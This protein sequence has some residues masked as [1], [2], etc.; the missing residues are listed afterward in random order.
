[1]GDT[2]E[3]LINEARRLGEDDC[4]HSEKGHFLAARIW[5][6]AGYLTGG[7]I[8]VLGAVIGTIEFNE[9]DVTRGVIGTLAIVIAAISSLVTFLNPQARAQAHQT[10]GNHYSA[11]RGKLRRFAMIGCGAG[12]P[13]SELVDL[14]EALAERKDNLNHEG[15]PVPTWAYRL[16][17]WGIRR[18][19]AS[20][21]VDETP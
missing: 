10:R 15:P 9:W 12:K 19:E 6:I 13:E 4:L 8:A 5:R 3:D 2:T 18:G 14:L 20:Y 11:L 17:K 1:M 16:A 21:A 7:L